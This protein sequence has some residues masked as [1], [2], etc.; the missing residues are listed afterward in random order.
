MVCVARR[1]RPPHGCC[2][3]VVLGSWRVVT[4]EAFTFAAHDG[5]AYVT[6]VTPD[7]GAFVVPEMRA[8]QRGSQ[9]STVH[10]GAKQVRYGA[11]VFSG[12]WR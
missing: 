5:G 1:H 11:A 3:F 7:D 10:G 9:R 2:A 6:F 4:A 12:G 8:W